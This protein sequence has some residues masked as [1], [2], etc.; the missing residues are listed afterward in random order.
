MLVYTKEKQLENKNRCSNLLKWRNINRKSVYK[1]KTE[2][3]NGLESIFGMITMILQHRLNSFSQGPKNYLCIKIMFRIKRLTGLIYLFPLT[4]K[5]PLT[6]SCVCVI[7]RSW[8]IA[9][10]WM[11]NSINK[12]EGL[13]T[14]PFSLRTC[15]SF[16][17]FLWALQLFL[18]YCF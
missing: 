15:G 14:R 1:A 5:H 13:V 11:K 3:V 7:C 18:C 2:Y 9:N 6:L 4:W 16:V 17:P 8:S 10:C 12:C